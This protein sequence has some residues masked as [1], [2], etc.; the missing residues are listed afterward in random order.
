MYM[1]TMKSLVEKASLRDLEHHY[2]F[3]S[4][5]AYSVLEPDDPGGRMVNVYDLSKV[6]SQNS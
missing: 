6:S 2:M 5:F 4:E 1:Y 3:V